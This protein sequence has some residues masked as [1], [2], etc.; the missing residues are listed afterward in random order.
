[1]RVYFKAFFLLSQLIL[2]SDIFG[3]Q[4]GKNV[5]AGD[6][7]STAD[8]L[9]AQRRAR[10]AGVLPTSEADDIV[11][12]Q[13]GEF[14]EPMDER[15]ADIE[16][17]EDQEGGDAAGEVRSGLE[18]DNQNTNDPFGSDL[19]VAGEDFLLDQLTADDLELES[20]FPARFPSAFP[21]SEPRRHGLFRL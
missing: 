10:A 1:M 14:G 8:L 2:R 18:P 13:L 15:E 4:V 6:G 7:P 16:C 20:R 3:A 12:R 11:A 5:E 21:Q 17:Q 9:D 19:S